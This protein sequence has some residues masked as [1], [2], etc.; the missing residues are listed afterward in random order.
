MSDNISHIQQFR[1]GARAPPA[2]MSYWSPREPRKAH[3]LAVDDNVEELKLLLEG[4][5]ETG[6]RI[7]LAFEALEGYRKATALQVDLVLLDVRMG[8]ADGFTVCR[9][10]KADPLTAH[11]P[12]I[13]VTSSISV[14]ERLTGLRT[15]A[16]DYILKPFEPTEVLA[17]VE[18][19][20]ALAERQGRAMSRLPD[21]PHAPMPVGGGDM[22][23]A[24][25]H[26]AET[27]VLS[28]LGN[29][30]SLAELAAR[31]GTH[32]KRLSRAFKEKTGR[33]VF[34]FVRDA[35]L[36]EGRRLLV[37]S[38]LSV[39]EVADTLG[40]SSAA[41]FA[42]TFRGRFG[43]TPTACRHA[44]LDKDRQQPSLPVSAG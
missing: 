39:E 12:V 43:C 24:Q 30:P 25:V 41:N 10:L 35:R 38:A 33:T 9:L 5:R 44:G 13:F 7:S 40:F 3:I 19:H 37:E 6:Y 11:V 28:D 14:E 29:V 15:G 23:L 42:T 22:D 32:E 20:L 4:L 34:E 36:C 26:A 17:R 8:A 2:F 16:V 18:I 31:V 27:L 21:T 1:H